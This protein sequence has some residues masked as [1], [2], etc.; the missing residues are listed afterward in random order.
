MAPY[1]RLSK[2]EV[3]LKQRPW[4]SH[5]ILELMNDRD[6]FNKQYIKETDPDRK[7]ILFR[8]YKSKRNIVVK[9]IRQ[10]RNNYYSEFF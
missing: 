2:K 9:T 6:N 7:S 5:E 3:G 10:S 8:F 1:K 4:I